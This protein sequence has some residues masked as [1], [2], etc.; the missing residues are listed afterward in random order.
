[1]SICRFHP[2]RAFWFGVGTF[3][4]TAPLSPFGSSFA[5]ATVP[6]TGTLSGSGQATYYDYTPGTGNCSFIGDDSDSMVA[7]MNIVDYDNSAM[8]GRYVRITGGS[9]SIDIRI[10]D[11][12]PSCAQGDID[13]NRAAFAQLAD[14]S[15]GVIPISWTT[16]PDP[17]TGNV[18]YYITSGSNPYYV[19][20][21]PR[22]TRY[23]VASLEYLSPTGYVSAPRASYNVFIID[24]TL[25]VP[26]PLENP[27][28]VRI[29]YV[30]GQVLTQSQIPLIPG[31]VFDGDS[32][33]ELCGTTTAVPAISSRSAVLYPPHP[34]PFNPATTLS[35]DL[36]RDGMVEL[37][38]FDQSGR[39]V[40]ILLDQ[41]MTAGHHELQWKG[42][43][44]E[45]KSVASGV[46]FL[47]LQTGQQTE[48]QRLVMGK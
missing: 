27:F 42:R 39:L 30:N 7:A 46:Y 40:R 16:I 33:F 37:K 36:S 9:G 32:Q 19:Q 25:G 29:S 1:M 11:S 48:T 43:D 12:C 8:C 4:L 35:F 44:D 20:V 13:L 10:V 47:Q 26:L 34:N 15:E 45:G 5:R 41:S 6:C 23:G 22:H 21:Q 2:K 24:G 28:T 17:T 18:Q 38:I 31:N 14:L 3:L